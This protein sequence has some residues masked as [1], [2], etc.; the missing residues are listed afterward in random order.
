[1]S[2]MDAAERLQLRT[3]LREGSV[4]DA[5][6]AMAQLLDVEDPNSLDPEDVSASLDAMDRLGEDA[7]ADMFESFMLLASRFPNITVPVLIKRIDQMP[8]VWSAGLAAATLREIFDNTPGG[9]RLLSR[10]GALP[11]LIGAVD[12]G[13]FAADQA[14]GLLR[15]WAVV[16]PLSKAE[17]QSI[18]D[19]LM[20]QAD[21]PAPRAYALRSA[22][23]ALEASGQAALLEPVRARTRDLPPDHPL[24][25]VLGSQ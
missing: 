10:E 25:R 13:G 18:A 5:D 16:Q 20:R 21:N 22:R 17:A 12:S 2:S 24:R 19:W 23:E 4:R 7:Q 11:A 6:A 9:P 1:M 15:D 14:V 8:G 3:Q